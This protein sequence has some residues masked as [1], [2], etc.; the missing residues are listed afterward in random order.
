MMVNLN[1]TPAN[2]GCEHAAPSYLA[3]NIPVRLTEHIWFGEITGGE[4]DY[5]DLYTYFEALLNAVQHDAYRL[6]PE[7]GGGNSGMILAQNGITTLEQGTIAQTTGAYTCLPFKEG[8]AMF[9]EVEVE[10][11]T[12]WLI[13]SVRWEDIALELQVANQANDNNSDVVTV[14]YA[15]IIKIKPKGGLVVEF[16]SLQGGFDIQ[17]LPE[18]SDMEAYYLTPHVYEPSEGILGGTQI[19][20]EECDGTAPSR[21]TIGEKAFYMGHYVN[22]TSLTDEKIESLYHV[23][24]NYARFNLGNNPTMPA[25]ISVP[26]EQTSLI[27]LADNTEAI[28]ELLEE[29]N[30]EN[31]NDDEEEEEEQEEPSLISEENFLKVPIPVS[32]L[33]DTVVAG[34]VCT[35]RTETVKL[36]EGVVDGEIIMSENDYSQVFVWWQVDLNLLGM[37]LGS[38]WIAESITYHSPLGRADFYLLTPDTFVSTA[39]NTYDKPLWLPNDI[40]IP[41]ATFG[42]ESSCVGILPS[43]LFSSSLAQPNGSTLNLRA[44]P[45]GDVIGIVEADEQFTVFGESL[46]WGG[47]RWWQTSRG[48]W[49]AE[50]SRTTALLLPAIQK[51]APPVETEMA[52]TAPIST[53]APTESTPV[54]TERVPVVTEAPTQPPRPTCDVVTG[55]NC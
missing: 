24:V 5:A 13:E 39:P 51:I 12:G 6:S 47:Y 10:G 7:A 22:E 43:T 50:N 25:Y 46:C 21:L 40:R 31:P 18:L 45:N 30:G 17:A 2:E 29:F 4:M 55:A 26:W 11:Q 20:Q 41:L 23:I 52:Q 42:N 33:I 35:R 8:V 28:E 19:A 16:V 9:W 49:V 48:G 53:P 34:P 15:P 44:V 1:Y 27:D 14:Q 37:D 36:I 38:V 54:P 32:Q 3:P